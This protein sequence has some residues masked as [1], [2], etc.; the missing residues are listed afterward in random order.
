MEKIVQI[1]NPT[2]KSH[3]NEVREIVRAI[4]HGFFHN[5][6][7]LF[8]V[9]TYCDQH[10]EYEPFIHLKVQTPLRFSPQG[11]PFL[12]VSV[13]DNKLADEFVRDG[14]YD[15]EIL[16]SD[17]CR[18]FTQGV[19][20]E[21]RSIFTSSREESNLFRYL[22]RVN[23]TKMRRSAWQ[24]KNLP[25]GE[26]SPWMATFL[27][28][29]Y[30]E[31]IEQRCSQAHEIVSASQKFICCER[32]CDCHS[33]LCAACAVKK[34]TMMPCDRCNAISYCSERCQQNHWPVH[35]LNCSSST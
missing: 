25:R 8:V 31:D 2:F 11:A 5:S 34:I 21:F 12:L 10:D 29:L 1:K 19:A 18:I 16:Q 24:S 9:H 27:S 28:P 33:S 4:F 17:Y 32:N 30:A 35:Q 20:R 23:S 14:K 22:L 13:L 7:H 26:G 6:I 15:S 3:L